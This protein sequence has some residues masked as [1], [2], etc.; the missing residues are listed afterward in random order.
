M[1]LRN[2]GCDRFLVQSNR[3]IYMTGNEK[4][5]IQL[6][7]PEMAGNK[8]SCYQ[9]HKTKRENESLIIKEELKVILTR[10]THQETPRPIWSLFLY[11]ITINGPLHII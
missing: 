11:K 3:K 2:N 6:V 1:I 7:H 10:R 9:P 8:V 5:Q 4:L